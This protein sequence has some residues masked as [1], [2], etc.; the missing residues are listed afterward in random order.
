MLALGDTP[1]KIVVAEFDGGS[2][3]KTVFEKQIG[4]LNRIRW[5]H[6]ILTSPPVNGRA[7]LT[8][9]RSQYFC[10]R[11]RLGIEWLYRIRSRA[12]RAPNK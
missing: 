12:I 3:G 2:A 1:N 9:A 4:N 11:E 7:K 10:R 5:R 8:A 6:E